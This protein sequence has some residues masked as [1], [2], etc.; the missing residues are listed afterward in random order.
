MLDAEL[1]DLLERKSPDQLSLL[2]LEQLRRALLESGPLRTELLQRRQMRPYL[3]DALARIDVSLDV[4]LAQVP[5][6]APPGRRRRLAAALVL[7]LL[8][9]GGAA[10]WW[11]RGRGE[12]STTV[13]AAAEQDQSARPVVKQAP[14][15]HETAKRPSAE[16]SGAAPSSENAP[17]ADPAPPA[18][19]DETKTASKTAATAESS[20][21]EANTSASADA[22]QKPEGPARPRVHG[23]WDAVLRAEAPR[24]D[25]SAIAFQPFRTPR[26]TPGKEDV[27]QWFKPTNSHAA[28][29]EKRTSAGNCGSISGVLRLQA[30][31]VDGAALRF[32]MEDYDRLKIHAFQGERGATL[33]FYQSQNYAWTAYQTARQA[34]AAQPDKF[35]L[36]A[37]DGGRNQRT[38]IRYGG[39]Y[40]LRFRDGALLL[41]RGDTLLVAAPM[42]GAPDEIYFD[43]AAAFLG[44]TMVKTAEDPFTLPPPLD[45]AAAIPAAQLAWK[46]NLAEGVEFQKRSDGAVELVGQ[47][48]KQRGFVAAPLPGEGLREVVL[49]LDAASPGAAVFLG[50]GDEGRPF[51][52]VKFLRDQR[53]GRLCL[54]L[55]GD[56]DAFERQF[57]SVEER[58]VPFVAE[59]PWLR[60]LF[61]CGVLR[62][63]LSADGRHWAEPFHSLRTG[64]P[65]EVTH[66]G[67]HVAAN[68][69][70]CR[71]VLRSV[72]T[73]PLAALM[74]LVDEPL[75]RQAPAFSQAGDYGDWLAKVAAAQ[76]TEADS[77]AWRRACAVNTLSA[78]CAAPLGDALLNALLDDA[79][80]RLSVE[81]QL[82]VLEE[83]ARLLDLQ[84]D[85]N[86]LAQFIA[87]YHRLGERAYRAGE[88][89]P[90]S[91]VRQAI[92]T[93]PIATPHRV[94]ARNE[95]LIRTELL[96]LLDAGQWRAALDFC[97]MLRFYRL[98]E[99][100]PLAAFARAAAQRESPQEAGAVLLAEQRDAW[101]HP[102]VEELSKD[103]YNF[104]A[105][106]QALLESE[107]FDEA[108]RM[109]AAVEPHAA[110]GVAADRR[111]PRLLVS[112]PAAIRLA[113]RDRPALRAVMEEQFADLAELRVRRAIGQGDE[114]AVRSAA[115]QFDATPAAA[116]A[117][118]WLG[119]RALSRGYFEQ[120]LA[121]YDRAERTAAPAQRA[122]LS[123]RKRLTGA[124]L[125][126]D[127][128]SSVASAVELGDVRIP[129]DEFETLVTQM[130]ERA[131]AATDA[132]RSGAAAAPRLQ[133][134]PSPT[135]FSTQT[136]GRLDGPAGEKPHELPRSVRQENVDW[137]ARQLAW[138]IEGNVLYVSNRFH[139]AAYDL[140]SGQRRWQSPAP[141]GRPARAHEWSLTPMRPLVTE[142]HILV[143]QLNADGPLLACLNKQDGK[144]VWTSQPPQGE[145]LASDPLPAPGGLL[146]FRLRRDSSREMSL[147]LCDYDIATGEPLD[148]HELLRLR[149]SS[150]T[151]RYVCQATVV[152]D[153]VVA[154]LGGC[155]VC[156][157]LTGGVRWVRRQL[158][159]PADE[160]W[161]GGA[162]HHD[163]PLAHEGRVFLAQPGVRSIECVDVE[164]GRSYW[165]RVIPDVQRVL[166]V[167]GERLIVETS[168]GFVALDA[169]S[170]ADAWRRV[171]TARLEGRL[172]DEDKLLYVRRV[173]GERDDTNLRPELVWLDIHTGEVVATT[174]LDGLNRKELT[175]GPIIAHQDRL[176]AF[177]GGGAHEP[178]RDLVELA[179]QG[180]ARLPV[181]LAEDA[182]MRHFPPAVQQAA[183]R[184]L[185]DWRLFRA[186]VEKSSGYYAEQH[187]E[188]DVLA[189][190]GSRSQPMTFARQVTLPRNAHARLRIRLALDQ[191]KPS[192][193]QVEFRGQE[194]WAEELSEQKLSARVW[195][196]F[197]ASLASHAGETGWLV[198]RLSPE[199]DER[200]TAFWKR[201]EVAF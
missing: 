21:G 192:R 175:F 129:P 29:G 68:R 103:A 6:A 64:L 93:A 19:A 49:Q 161:L 184:V 164:T 131:S 194:V 149:E 36:T 183:A 59:R 198:I 33:A 172:G 17:S 31:L 26:S 52:I 162:Q 107:A 199:K 74:A 102:L 95:E 177:V 69:P 10:A 174:V 145:W 13:S 120:A 9:A 80:A 123:P 137:A 83:A 53:T 143:R 130:R 138:V 121:L 128:G 191:V 65:G 180:E 98:D 15:A 97:E 2:E 24:S 44:L 54:A 190:D 169:H 181:A 113:M 170:G 73:R 166:G 78:G 160:D 147:R 193:L 50:R 11:T 139:V 4:L 34:G 124:M 150:W 114:T 119:D 173:A 134:A 136:R 126:R 91:L 37:T 167:S 110:Q 76:P 200:I 30:P 105:E 108:A 157:D 146:A 77:L 71:L 90:F 176:W 27:A 72:Q 88:R 12:P 142:K 84:S 46:P 39:P 89:R 32:A 3:T 106:F 79:A 116:L 20:K 1:L 82:A 16:E 151:G 156:V 23:P 154:M 41:S 100:L 165:T 148:Q 66:L 5:P 81:Q 51:E 188:K 14:A 70:D 48:A 109:I 63:W 133:A 186:I 104:L 96:E 187:G 58:T 45:A 144:V 178:H 135:G 22:E 101:R 87:R 171:D 35:V 86:R 99:N 125:G 179:P 140:P 201:L 141:P 182:W 57:E 118:R 132:V 155:A 197:E 196:D 55:H 61:G 25:F 85:G 67:L 153:A 56:D 115:L 60:L 47:K 18:S 152:D 122:E 168:Q 62:C 28:V 195:R 8:T 158:Y 38:E 94:S 189:L 112:L 92:M 75:R 163:P 159:L 117:A 127:I 43:G 7:L 111:D 42:E 40:E 185:H